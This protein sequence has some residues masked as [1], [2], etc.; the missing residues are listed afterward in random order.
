MQKAEQR[1]LLVV[2]NAPIRW[3]CASQSSHLNTRFGIECYRI[4]HSQ[5]KQSLHA[6]CRLLTLKG[7]EK[8]LIDNGPI[9]PS[10]PSASGGEA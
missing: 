8:A 5:V 1:K 2:R 6:R 4:S 9:T 3:F 7:Y 10:A